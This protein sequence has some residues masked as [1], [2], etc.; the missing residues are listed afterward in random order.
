MKTMYELKVF[1]S[2]SAKKI[3]QN[4]NRRLYYYFNKK[5]EISNKI[6]AMPSIKRHIKIKWWRSICESNLLVGYV[7]FAY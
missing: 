1:F 7:N 5:G 6:S 2:K 4:E 3:L